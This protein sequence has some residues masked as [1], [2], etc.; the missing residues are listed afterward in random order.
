MVLRVLYGPG[1]EVSM[2]VV[3]RHDY[4]PGEPDSSDGVYPTISLDSHIVVVFMVPEM[5]ILAFNMASGKAVTIKT[6]LPHLVAHLSFIYA[7]PRWL[8]DL[9]AGPARRANL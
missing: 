8:I 7:L 3:F 1:R 5:N 6:D 9:F 2:G 4:A